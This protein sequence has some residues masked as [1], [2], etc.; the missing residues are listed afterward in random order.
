MGKKSYFKFFAN[1]NFPLLGENSFS[2]PANSNYTLKL[3]ATVYRFGQIQLNFNMELGISSTSFNLLINVKRDGTSIINGPQTFVSLNNILPNQINI[4]P[5][6]FSTIDSDAPVGKH[7]YTIELMNP[8]NNVANI[9]YYSL[10]AKSLLEENSAEFFSFQF[11]PQ[12]NRT[13]MNNNTVSNNNTS[14]LPSSQMNI[15]LNILTKSMM[16]NN[17][18]EKK[19]NNNKKQVKLVANLNVIFQGK[20]SP[21]FYM[22]L[23]KDGASITGGP[24]VYFGIT[25]A[26]TG[27]TDFINERIINLTLIDTLDTDNFVYTLVLMNRSVDSRAIIDYLSFSAELTPPIHKRNYFSSIQNFPPTGTIAATIQPTA[28]IVIPLKLKTKNKKKVNI[29][30]TLNT[31]TPIFTPLL[32]YDIRRD[33]KSI[34]N[35]PQVLHKANELVGLRPIDIEVNLNSSILNKVKKGKYT[36]TLHLINEGNKPI[37]VDIYSFVIEQ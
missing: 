4:I 7:T 31:I 14:L 12:T 15:P 1:E 28:N 10:I 24:Q 34:T 17:K 11:Y 23:L 20:S 33:N 5:Q 25:P 6:T 8:S 35:G 36:Y 30:F 18:K 9:N 21:L 37:N 29:S 19:E 2:I 26:I 16:V 13:L 22:D 3:N 27:S 32:L